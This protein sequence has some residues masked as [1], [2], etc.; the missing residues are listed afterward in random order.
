M[1]TRA[2]EGVREFEASLVLY[3]VLHYADFSKEFLVKTDFSHLAI[4]AV[5]TQ[6][7]DDG[8]EY[9]IAYV[10]RRCQGKESSYS[11]RRGEAVVL[12]FAVKKWRPFLEGQQFTVISD[13]LSLGFCVN[14]RTT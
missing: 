1:G 2:R 14:L 7:D 9:P 12:W 10:S 8:N 4:G 3:P 13:H 11:A 5:L 6:V